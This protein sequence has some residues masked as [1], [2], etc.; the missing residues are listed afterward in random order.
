MRVAPEAFRM[1]HYQ[2]LSRAHAIRKYVERR[3]D[4]R[5]LRERRWHGWRGRLTPEMVQL[6]SAS[7]LRLYTSDDA[8]DD[9]QPRISHVLAERFAQALPTA[10][11]PERRSAVARLLG[12]LGELARDC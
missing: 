6:P 12:R 5:E 9:R 1:R 8:L 4:E 10:R 2:F 3:Y 11:L 7:E